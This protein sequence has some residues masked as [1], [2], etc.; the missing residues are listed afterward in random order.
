MHRL[1]FEENI[2]EL[3]AALQGNETVHIKS[4]LSI[5]RPAMISNIVLQILR[6]HYSKIILKVAFR[7]ANKTI[8]AHSKYVRN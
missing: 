3:I 5:S 8:A 4:I 1:G 6:L 2:T 7:I